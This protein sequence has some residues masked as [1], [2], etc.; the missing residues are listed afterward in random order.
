MHSYQ[1]TI[2]QITFKFIFKH[3]RWVYITYCSW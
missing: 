2:R 1:H 3:C